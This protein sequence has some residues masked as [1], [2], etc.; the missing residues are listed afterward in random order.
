MVSFTWPMESALKPQLLRLR[1][2]F[3]LTKT[4]HVGRS[5]PQGFP[6]RPTRWCGLESTLSRDLAALRGALP[7]DL[8]ADPAELQ[9]GP[10]HLL[11]RSHRSSRVPKLEVIR[12]FWSFVCVNLWADHVGMV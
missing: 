12:L 5:L 10:V 3:L 9:T 4:T 6:Q 7:G 1:A 11:A 2:R 8:Q